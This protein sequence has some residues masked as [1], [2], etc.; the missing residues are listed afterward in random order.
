MEVAF[1]KQMKVV[2]EEISEHAESAAML[3]RCEC[4]QHGGSTRHTSASMEGTQRSPPPP[5]TASPPLSPLLSQ[6]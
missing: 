4:Q 6:Q 5:L 2:E 1:K 3:S